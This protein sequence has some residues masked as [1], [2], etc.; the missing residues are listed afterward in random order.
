MGESS[1]LRFL[2]PFWLALLIIM[3][4]DDASGLTFPNQRLDR[5]IV[6]LYNKPPNVVTTHAASDEKGRINVF[7]DIRSM[8]G[9]PTDE[10]TLERMRGVH[11]DN[12][13]AVGR[14]DVDTT[15][16]L[17]VTNDGGLVHHVTNKDSKSSAAGPLGKTYHA[18]IMGYHEDASSLIHNIRSNGVDIGVKYGGHTLPVPDIKVLG[19]PSPKTTVVQLTLY[20][21]K[22]RQIRRMFH[23]LG[24]GVMKLTRTA[25]GKY[26]TL[27]GL[28]E[29]GWRILSDDEVRSALQWQPRQLEN[30]ASKRRIRAGVN[31]ESA[32]K[33][34][35]PRP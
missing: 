10:V 28:P 5:T 9:C 4:S 3:R 24:S 17:L 25:I 1:M 11:L 32:I 21:G 27:H 35:M 15:G 18:Q 31:C 33:R 26:L 34:R 6:L 23:A 14:L 2:E 20:E 7:D 19:H 8:R 30:A 13:H 22:N 29:G 12:W 16:L